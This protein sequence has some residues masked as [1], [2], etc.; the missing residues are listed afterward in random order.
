MFAKSVMKQVLAK[1][2][3][4]FLAA[5]VS[6]SG[7]ARAQGAM[8]IAALVNDQ[9]ISVYDLGS[10]IDLTILSLGLPRTREV[11][12]KLA[13]QVLRSLI[14]EKLQLQEA[15][16]LGVSVTESMLENALKDIGARNP[17]ANGDIRAFVRSQGIDPQTVADQTKAQI[18]W[19]GVLNKEVRRKV[20]I[21][22][23]EIDAELE[24]MEANKKKPQRLVSEIFFAVNDP[25]NE[26]EI[27]SL[28]DRIAGQL[29]AGGNFARLAAQFSQSPS[30]A[31]QGDLGWLHGGQLAPELERVLDGLKPGEISA[32]IRTLTGYYILQLRG[33]RSPGSEAAERV[34]LGLHQIVLPVP[35][36]ATKEVREAI[37][38]QGR[39]ITEKAANCT[40]M[41]AIGKKVGSPMS[42]SLGT[43]EAGKLPPNIRNI[44]ETLPINRASVPV[45]NESGVMVLMVCSREAGTE[46]SEA[47]KREQ[48]KQAL[49]NERRELIARQLMR[50]LHR[51][52]IIDIRL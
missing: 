18:A 48:I 25:A 26:Q 21:T 22:K 4:V 15:E 23:D 29:K 46:V 37:M 28:A 52:A 12:Q 17:A 5:L 38:D 50:D 3:L 41:E 16:R 34:K 11:Q 6:H 30:A 10:R 42:G 35:G 45:M 9:A 44:V 8:G 19:Y 32:P 7:E 14:D 47:A 43:I 1:L 33:Q 27:R 24:Q 39:S 36:N 51:N 40:D 2:F 20:N 49:E 13:P 31:A